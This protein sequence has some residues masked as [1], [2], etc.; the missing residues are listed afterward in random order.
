MSSCATIL[1][2]VINDAARVGELLREHDLASACLQWDATI[3]AGAAQAKAARHAGNMALAAGGFTLLAGTAALFGA[4]YAGRSALKGVDLQVEAG[5]QQQKIER[6]HLL[7][8]EIY[9]AAIT[10]LFSDLLAI[11]RFSDLRVSYEDAFR[12]FLDR[13]PA[14]ARVHMVGS[15]ETVRA[16]LLAV[17]GLSAVHQD[18][19]NMRMDFDAEQVDYP[20][21]R[22][23]IWGKRCLSKIPELIPEMTE[24]VVTMRSEL[25]LPIETDIYQNLI[26][27]I[28]VRSISQAESFLVGIENAQRR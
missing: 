15:I 17:N 9:L 7:K 16:V 4:I 18:L 25:G 14:L 1:Q 23:L 12:D 22:P 2:S 8:R 27:I 3:Q 5:K 10:A 21:S 13:A 20:Q 6:E 19:F 24:A 28:T 26:E 11:S